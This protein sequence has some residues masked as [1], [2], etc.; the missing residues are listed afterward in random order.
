[1]TTVSHHNTYELV[2]TLNE[3]NR[4]KSLDLDTKR[5]DGK[6]HI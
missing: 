3:H 6:I 1:M 4:T 5:E 2:I